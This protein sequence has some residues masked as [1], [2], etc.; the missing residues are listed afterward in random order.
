MNNKKRE[1]EEYLERLWCMKEDA[2]DSKDD[3]KSMI[4]H[5]FDESIIDELVHK[6]LVELRENGER[7][8]LTKKGLASAQ[9]II[10][11]HRIAER[12]IYDILGDEFE[13]G[14]CEFEHIVTPEIV[15]SI[16]ILLGHP[17]ECPHGMPIPK[18]E[19]CK[20]SARTV[21]SKVSP[22]IESKIGQSARIAYVNCKND[23][24]LHKIDG[25]QIRPNVIVKL[26]QTY[27][28]YVI[29]CEGAYIALDK[30]IVSNI[31]VWNKP[32]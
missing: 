1:K 28:S 20:Q 15:D 3:L 27:P 19:C 32:L 2:K 25:L 18:G 10:R 31:F 24:Q 8:N 12:L 7:I 26:H 6:D 4:N 29:E 5:S 21:E 17:R 16:C 30:E 11:S 23:Q 9:L 13:S 22:L 14:A